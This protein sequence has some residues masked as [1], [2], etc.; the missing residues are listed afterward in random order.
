MMGTIREQIQQFGACGPGATPAAGFPGETW[1]AMR[2]KNP[3]D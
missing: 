3:I 2:Q 1:A